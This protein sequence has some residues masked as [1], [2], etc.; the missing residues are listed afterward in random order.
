M[1]KKCTAL[2]LVVALFATTL[3]AFAGSFPDV[4]KNHWATE[5]VETLEELGIFLGYPDGEFK[6]SQPATRYEMA[7]VI[8]R[9]WQQLINAMDERYV[10]QGQVVGEVVPAEDTL[11]AMIE[12]QLAAKGYVTRPEAEKIAEAK[13]REVMKDLLL[14]TDEYS[15]ELGD[16]GVEVARL[17]L[18]CGELDTRVTDLESGLAGLDRDF[19]NFQKKMDAKCEMMEELKTQVD[20]LSKRPASN[21]GVSTEYLTTIE[22]KL[23]GHDK[24]IA[25]LENKV[26]NH[27]DRIGKL[28]ETAAD[29]EL[30][31]SAI[32]DRL[33]RYRINAGARLISDG[34]RTDADDIWLRPDA[35]NNWTNLG[36][37]GGKDLV[38]DYHNMALGVDMGVRVKPDPKA[39][40]Y[41]NL[42]AFF[43]GAA[44]G[45]PHSYRADGYALLDQYEVG[46][47]YL[48][49]SQGLG[50]YANS[51][52][53]SEKLTGELGDPALRG[54]REANLM[55][56][57]D[58]F[59]FG[60][61]WQNY[62]KAQI[63]TQ[64]IMGNFDLFEQMS[65]DA[66]YKLLDVTDTDD[67]GASVEHNHRI[68]RL[69][70]NGDFEVYN[71]PVAVTLGAAQRYGKDDD[72]EYL[73]KYLIDANL[74]G[75][76][77]T[78][79]LDMNVY[80]RFLENGSTWEGDFDGN[81]FVSA[82]SAL[83][84]ELDSV[85]SSDE[86]HYAVGTQ[87]RF[88]I[89]DQMYATGNLM[90][91]LNP[92]TDVQELTMGAGLGYSFDLANF[93]MPNYYVTALFDYEQIKDLDEG[94]IGNRLERS[95]TIER[96]LGNYSGFFGSWRLVEGSNNLARDNSKDRYITAGYGTDIAGAKLRFFYNNLATN[97]NDIT[98]NNL[99]KMDQ[100]VV[101]LFYAF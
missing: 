10:K 72:V 24:S 93:A 54:Y 85:W 26:D 40:L 56:G 52:L 88:K 8:H 62:G 9:A 1:R 17:K 96:P 27:E 92:K 91:D 36:A 60:S 71:Y 12:E 41:G 6:G 51:L 65:L 59:T 13:A 23:I 37:K 57:A 4:P 73:N 31:L 70:A 74:Y 89:I 79:K 64:E 35:L 30:R 49:L 95:V 66:S 39:D 86:R 34:V 99:E 69:A 22:N 15:P 77:P 25:Q 2:F 53:V 44:N 55:V 21:G 11:K 38:N 19:R 76:R 16:M 3:P 46:V 90:Y 29:H 48:S 45:V 14:A 87:A 82:E 33:N 5:S 68:I 32:E 63:S 67:L 100:F 84:D 75:I 42:T 98:S 47:S 61:R 58:P 80:A 94:K 7:V 97:Q 78:P 101:D 83:K 18:L 20:L 81:S 43:G 28:E 50:Y